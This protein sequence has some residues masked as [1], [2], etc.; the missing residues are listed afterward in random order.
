MVARHFYA[1]RSWTLFALLSL[2]LL[3]AGTRFWMVQTYTRSGPFMDTWDLLSDFVI[4]RLSGKIHLADWFAAHNEHRIVTTRLLLAGL[5]H[6]NKQW[7]PQLNEAADALIWSLFAVAMAAVLLR[8]FPLRLRWPVLLAVAVY[9]VAPFGWEST[10][11]DF[12]SQNYFNI[13]FSVVAL[14]GLSR[15]ENGDLPWWLGLGAAVLACLSAGSGML[16]SL[17]VVA[18]RTLRALRERAWPT[19]GGWITLASCA[20]IVVGDLVTRPHPAEPLSPPTLLGQWLAFCHFMAWPY[21]AQ[22]ALAAWM[23]A[24]TA[25]LLACYLGRRS[26]SWGRA[27]KEQQLV[28]LLLAAELW[29]SLQ[30][31]AMAHFRGV[32]VAILPSRYTDYLAVGTLASFLAWLL[33]GT[34]V[35]S[36]PYW[37]LAIWSAAALWT[38]V[39]FRG[40]W[41]ES[42]ACYAGALPSYLASAETI[43]ANLRGY[44]WTHDYS[45]FLAGKSPMEI[46]FTRND[47]V[48]ATLDNPVL[49]PYLPAGIRAP[50]ALQP[51]Q[52]GASS[53]FSPGGFDPRTGE[54]AFARTWGS[55]QAEEGAA[56]QGN[57]LATLDTSPE[58]PYLRFHFAG[59]LGE[60]GVELVLRDRASGRRAT[61]VPVRV[62]GNRWYG[63]TIGKP[64][65]HVVIEASD[66]SPT[67]WFAF[68]EPV[69]IGAWSYWSGYVLRHAEYLVLAGALG[70][71]VLAGW[72]ITLALPATSVE[73]SSAPGT[74][75]AT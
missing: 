41:A 71:L 2:F 66:H 3:V 35:T 64:G 58:L 65:S 6:L 59:N 4:P 70:F 63:D 51:D 74:P 38:V 47:S 53:A 13:L 45:R 29:V 43:E 44:V 17:V 28:E 52:P 10:L 14:W 32:V 72:S 68:D 40:L 33:I 55:F 25:L 37:R 48:A 50:V 31:A 73:E 75:R 60:K 56:A 21:F 9:F 19:R 61:V 57:W 18:V 46:G 67:R 8:F 30:S 49:R 24:P 26:S 36:R 69:E 5:F 22:P 12:S 54:L 11:T 27:G 7:D 16:A 42:Q 39:V 34:A 23:L 62:P 1:A 20:L 15:R